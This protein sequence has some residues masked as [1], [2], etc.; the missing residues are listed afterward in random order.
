[1]RPFK[2]ALL[3]DL[4]VCPAVRFGLSPTISQSAE[5]I[6]SQYPKKQRLAFSVKSKKA[7]VC[8]VLVIDTTDVDGQ[9]RVDVRVEPKS[10]WY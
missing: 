6:I 10:D 3:P 5:K 4:N 2:S 8:Q 7:F 9:K 1:L